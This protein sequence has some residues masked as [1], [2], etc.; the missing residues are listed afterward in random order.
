[1]SDQL[2]PMIPMPEP[3]QPGQPGPTPD[4]ITR[5]LTQKEEQDVLVNF[6]GNMYGES[7]KMDGNIIAPS[8]TLQR[9]K[10][11]EI[12]K[13]I[14]QVIAQ[15]QQ[16]VPQQVQAAPLQPEPQ[17]PHVIAPVRPIEHQSVDNS[18]LSFNFNTTE[19]DELFI[20]IEKVSTRLDR[21]HKKVDD[22]TEIVKNS[23]VTS[24]P[25]KKAKKKSVDKK[26]E[27]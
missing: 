27:V 3:G 23:K 14:E 25:I 19:K 10:S 22:L 26:E 15:P 6:M 16:S 12:K 21:L 20:L 9:G 4:Q 7:K 5:Q 1:M 24:L 13:H 8:S 18:Q 17:Q 2:P 11:E